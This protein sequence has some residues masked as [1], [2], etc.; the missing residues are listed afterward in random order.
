MSRV[1]WLA[2]GDGTGNP[3]RGE[4]SGGLVSIY[5]EAH[6]ERLVDGLRRFGAS[7][8]L[9]ELVELLSTEDSL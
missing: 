6:R 2:R 4:C 1:G 7:G 9:K 3:G 8:T 5:S